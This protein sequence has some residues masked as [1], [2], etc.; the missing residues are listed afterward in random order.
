MSISAIASWN[1]QAN[2]A[3]NSTFP[4]RLTHLVVELQRRCRHLWRAELDECVASLSV[5]VD[6]HDRLH[7]GK[8]GPRESG[9]ECT[10]EDGLELLLRHLQKEVAKGRGGARART[11]HGVVVVGGRVVGGCG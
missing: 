2:T 11:A 9:H 10:I 3:N 7:A 5:A 1:L 4:W 8:V 6:A